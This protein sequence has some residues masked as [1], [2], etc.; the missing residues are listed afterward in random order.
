MGETLDACGG[1]FRDGGRIYT[2]SRVRTGSFTTRS[3][4]LGSSSDSQCIFYIVTMGSSNFRMG[5]NTCK[6]ANLQGILLNLI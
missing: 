6:G 4:V 1:T 2:F 5:N 3:L